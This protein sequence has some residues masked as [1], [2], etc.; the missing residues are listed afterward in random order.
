[1]AP[2]PPHERVETPPGVEAAPTP[3][4]ES[5]RPERI[6]REAVVDAARDPWRDRLRV[7]FD[8]AIY[9]GAL[10]VV[11]RLAL[12]HLLDVGTGTLVL[13]V[14]GI[15]P[16]NL[17]DVAQTARGSGGARAALALFAAPAAEAIRNGSWLAR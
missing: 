9:A 11:Y 12:A 13:L 1:M 7:I 8:R 2:P 6:E 4:I 14:A 16:H 5:E 10:W 17:F 15:R 3:N